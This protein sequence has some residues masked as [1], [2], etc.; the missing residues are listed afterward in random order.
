MFQTTCSRILALI[1][2]LGAPMVMASGASET[3]RLD[4]PAGTKQR[5]MPMK[6]AW[7]C[8]KVNT[9]EP[10]RAAHGPY[11]SFH[12]NGQKRAVGQLRDG[13][14]SG[15]WAYFDESGRKI[16]EIDFTAHHYD[17]RRVQFFSSG[18]VKLEERW[19][20][21]KREGTAVAYTEDGRKLAEFEYRGG[22]LVKEQRFDSSQPVADK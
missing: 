7:Y 4:C 3:V 1:L 14:L 12:P 21:G 16:E 18:K 8:S 2:S 11:M 5:R 15:H 13:M 9:S 20:N 6:S 17:G 10:G 19:V 22:H